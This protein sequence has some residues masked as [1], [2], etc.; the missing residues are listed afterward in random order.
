[1]MTIINQNPRIYAF[2]STPQLSIPQSFVTPPPEPSITIPILAGQIVAHSTGHVTTDG[3]PIVMLTPS[4]W[5]ASPSKFLSLNYPATNLPAGSSIILTPTATQPIAKPTPS[6]PQI[7]ISP[8]TSAQWPT[9]QSVLNNMAMFLPLNALNQF[10]TLIPTPD[11]PKQFPAAALLFLAAAK[12]GDLSG[13]MGTRTYKL[14][15]NAPPSIKKTIINALQDIPK[16]HGRTAMTGDPVIV[17]TAPEWRGHPIPML[18]GGD[19]H[20]AH[21]WTKYQ[22]DQSSNDGQK[23]AGG[24]R[25]IVDLKLSRMGDVQ[26]DGY[27]DKTKQVFNLSLITQK[28]V[29]IGMQD[30][31]K[32]LWY[33]TLEG[34]DLS[35]NISFKHD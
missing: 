12:G 35:G 14:L 34:L 29:Q 4:S 21:L 15:D 22:D 32:S 25:F 13:W 2:P 11:Q 26:F 5:P 31:L 20:Q 17:Q 16:S 30:I 7:N 19:V 6:I 33:K 10:M 1:V 9:M 27:I 28:P 18:V 8:A 3:N 24:T 23:R